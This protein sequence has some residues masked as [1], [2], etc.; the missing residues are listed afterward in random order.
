MNKIIGSLKP[1]AT[2]D[3]PIIEPRTVKKVC[4]IIQRF[5][6]IKRRIQHI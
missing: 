2:I 4:K 5:R 3:V 1:K 6:V